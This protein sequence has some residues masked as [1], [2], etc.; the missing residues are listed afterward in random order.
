MYIFDD[1]VAL[2]LMYM[3]AYLLGINIGRRKIAYP[4]G[5]QTVKDDEW[6]SLFL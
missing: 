2:F 6:L 1:F 5:I 3:K 4:I